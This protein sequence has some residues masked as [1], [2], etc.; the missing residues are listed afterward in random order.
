[1]RT[2]RF[3]NIE[4]AVLGAGLTGSCVALELANRGFSVAILD[5]DPVPMNRAS[6]RNEGKVHLGLIYAADSSL[7][8]ADLLLQGALSFDSLLTRWLGDEVKGL[9]LS[10]PFTYLVAQDSVLNHSQLEAHY[11]LIE[12]AYR[13]R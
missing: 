9:R 7:K 2:S 10:T 8:T 3:K 4:V 12:D 5:Q 6:R 13:R 11:A 1:M